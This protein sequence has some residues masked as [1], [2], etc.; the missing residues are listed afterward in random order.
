MTSKNAIA[1]TPAVS[2]GQRVEKNVCK[3]VAE[4][5]ATTAARPN[6]MMTTAVATSLTLGRQ[7]KDR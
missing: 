6:D 1:A 4:E 3:G 5:P 2:G 7:H